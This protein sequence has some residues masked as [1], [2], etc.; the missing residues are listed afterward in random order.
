[1]PPGST[2]TSSSSSSSASSKS[3]S[4][5]LRDR[6]G[7]KTLVAVSY[8]I[9][10][11]V[12]ALVWM[13]RLKKYHE[14]ASLFSVQSFLSILLA[15]HAKMIAAYMVHETCHDSIFVAKQDNRR[16]GILCLW[17]SGCPYVD[18][19]HVKHMHIAHHVDRTDLVEFDYRTFVKSHALIQ[20][21]ILALE[22]V[23]IPAV[24]II[25]H[26]RQALLPL[27]A[28]QRLPESNRA[29]RIR[30]ASI[31]TPVILLWYWWLWRRGVLLPQT[32]S[33]IILLH[34]LALNDAFHHTYE[35]AFPHDYTPGPGNRT[36]QYEEDNTFSNVWS[37]SWPALNV[38]ML[39]FGYHNAHH[40]RPMV[41]WHALPAYHDKLYTDKDPK[42]NDKKA[43]SVDASPQVLAV[44]DTYMAWYRH[45]LRR[46]V[47]EDYGVVYPLGTPDRAR[48]FVGALGVSFLTV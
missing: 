32:M 21:V 38:L 31:G 9:L 10:G 6:E 41:P 48:D 45:R 17:M 19:G 33:G 35:A 7:W 36:A 42:D 11:N 14:D 43:L 8:T 29:S 3:K 18:F 1:M 24:E 30:S 2:F 40:K 15:A 25:M 20:N 27:V 26:L 37:T 4:F 46:V 44:A 39:N 28:P 47:E 13:L 5:V 23:G 16:L 22:Y 34:V 12:A